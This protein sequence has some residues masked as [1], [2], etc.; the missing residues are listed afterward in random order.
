MKSLILAAGYGTRLKPLTEHIAKP[1]IPIAGIPVIEYLL[2]RITM[3]PII[4]MIYIVTNGQYFED[5]RNWKKT[6]FEKNPKNTVPI[7]LLNDGSL[8][9]ETRLGAVRDMALAIDTL[10][11]KDDLLISAADD[12]FTFDFQK[13]INRFNEVAH[14]VITLCRTDDVQLIR[15]SGNAEIDHEGRVLSM[16]EKPKN[17]K[18]N[19]ISPC[20]YILS[21]PA[22]RDIKRYLM[23]NLNP[24]APGH[25]IS[26][27]V[28]HRNVFSYIF[29]A[30]FYTIGTLE[31]YESVRYIFEK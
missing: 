16:I 22:L 24:D 19:L 7:E 13:L 18:T 9:N 27:L 14:S 5:F 15:N 1:L 2:N 30:P 29:T 25:F 26:W 11:I 31:A 28:K 17:P 4:D 23:K 8:S 21:Q 20:L 12:L 10:Q 6:F 3:L